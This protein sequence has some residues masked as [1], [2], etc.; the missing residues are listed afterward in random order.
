MAAVKKTL[1]TPLPS[2]AAAGGGGIS[3]SI[4][5]QR[6]QCYRYRAT[7][8]NLNMRK[9]SMQVVE[10]DGRC[11]VWFDHC[12]LEVRDAGRNLL[13]H[14]VAGAASNQLNAEIVIL[15]EF[16]LSAPKRLPRPSP[17]PAAA[18]LAVWMQPFVCQKKITIQ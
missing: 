15:A 7:A 14:L 4:T 8:V 10:N 9:V 13:F 5:N 12:D 18:P 16:V 3:I 17:P 6:G 1:P 2:A 11:F